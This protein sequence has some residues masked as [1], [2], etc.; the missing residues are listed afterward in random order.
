MTREEIDRHVAGIL[1]LHRRKQQRAGLL[2]GL[3]HNPR[4]PRIYGTGAVVEDGRVSEVDVMF[5]SRERHGWLPRRGD[6]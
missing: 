4:R 5:R 6:D 1:R 2:R 3:E